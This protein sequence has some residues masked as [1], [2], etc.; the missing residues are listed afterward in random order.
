MP[1]NPKYYD[2]DRAFDA[3]DEI[4]WKQGGGIRKGDTVYLYVAA[5]VSAIRYRCK[6]TETD[7]PYSFRDGSLSIRRVMRIRL[8]RR[9][10]PDRFP[11]ALLGEAFGIYAVRGPRG[12]PESLKRA[13]EL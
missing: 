7:L 8:L 9:Y 11:F 2:V 4:L 12:I 10:P 13:L 1:A 3:A 5:P 6:V